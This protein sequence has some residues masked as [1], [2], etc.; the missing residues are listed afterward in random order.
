MPS[1]Q[2]YAH[3]IVFALHSWKK[4]IPVISNTFNETKQ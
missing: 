2:S 4:D 1:P 3:V